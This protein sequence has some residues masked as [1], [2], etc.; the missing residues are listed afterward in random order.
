MMQYLNAMLD[1]LVRHRP[2]SATSL[3][4]GWTARQPT[5]EYSAALALRARNCLSSARTK[6][7][8]E[9]SL[10]LL[11]WGNPPRPARLIQIKVPICQPC[12]KFIEGRSLL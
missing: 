9:R 11:K 4:T 12:H 10:D 8:G 7:T 6:E 1:E 5:F 3:S 2:H